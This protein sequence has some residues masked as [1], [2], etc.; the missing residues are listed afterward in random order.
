[1][2]DERAAGWSEHGVVRLKRG[3]ECLDEVVRD[4]DEVVAQSGA[5]RAQ[6]RC[7]GRTSA[8]LAGVGEGSIGRTIVV[9]DASTWAFR[10][11]GM[12]VAITEGERARSSGWGRRPYG[13]SIIAPR[14][15]FWRRFG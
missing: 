12:A 2:A 6:T 1:M 15:R 9:D 11:S 13:V 7:C 5:R 10:G 4:G 8:I 3:E 14:L